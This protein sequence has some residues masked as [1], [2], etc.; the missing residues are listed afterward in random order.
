MIAGEHAP[1]M[2]VMADDPPDHRA[3][4]IKLLDT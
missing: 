2:P 3:I 1:A 4:K